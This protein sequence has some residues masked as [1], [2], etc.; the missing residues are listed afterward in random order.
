ME[1]ACKVDW[2]S[3]CRLECFQGIDQTFKKTKYLNIFCMYATFLLVFLYF[4][5]KQLEEKFFGFGKQIFLQGK[6]MKTTCPKASKFVYLEIGVYF[7][8]LCFM[9][10]KNF[11]ETFNE[12]FV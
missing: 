2:C 3:W 7:Q 1:I 8:G 12:T 5:A 11:S 10:F 6:F 9:I 4:W